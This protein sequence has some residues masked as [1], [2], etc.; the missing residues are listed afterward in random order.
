MTGFVS[1]SDGFRCDI[2][3][4]RTVKIK[5]FDGVAYI[6]GGVMYVP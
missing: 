1:L 4:V 6:L 3:G 5:M 2:T